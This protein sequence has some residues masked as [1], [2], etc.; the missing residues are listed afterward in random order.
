MKFLKRLFTKKSGFIY[1][2][3]INEI[4]DEDA[5]ISFDD[6][7]YVYLL[8]LEWEKGVMDIE[9]G[10]AG[11]EIHDTTNH[12]NHYNVMRTIAYITR[13]I[14]DSITRKTGTVFHTVTFKSSNWRDGDVDFKS[15]DIRNRFFARYVIHQ[16]PNADV[17]QNED[18]LITIK[19]NRV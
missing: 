14:A 7:Q 4:D 11:S 16:F 15:G 13:R 18:N 2:Y 3:T 9:F 19:L 8:E 10:I 1:P 17:V 6:G 12:N 5:I